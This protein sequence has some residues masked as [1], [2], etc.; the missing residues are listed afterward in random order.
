ML[1]V[2]YTLTHTHSHTHTRAHAWTGIVSGSEVMIINIQFA[3]LFQYLRV[4]RLRPTDLGTASSTG[5]SVKLLVAFIHLCACVS[6]YVY[7]HVD[8]CVCVCVC[9]HAHGL[10]SS[11]T[12]SVL[13]AVFEDHTTTCIMQ[14]RLQSLDRKTVRHYLR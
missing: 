9:M 7:V 13:L 6:K 14:F 2:S 3:V 10:S 4:P 5:I 8:V 12:Y 11:R 1:S